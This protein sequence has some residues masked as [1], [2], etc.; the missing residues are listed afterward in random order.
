MLPG[1][2]ARALGTERAYLDFFLKI[3]VLEILDSVKYLPNG[4]APHTQCV[5]KLKNLRLCPS[6][7]EIDLINII[8][9]AC[10]IYC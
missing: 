6:R 8:C 5:I 4:S 7:F 9:A 1:T 3:T 2:I 10:R